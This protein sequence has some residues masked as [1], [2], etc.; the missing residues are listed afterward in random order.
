MEIKYTVSYCTKN[1]RIRKR[2]HGADE[3]RTL[4]GKELGGNWWVLK[5]N[6]NHPGLEQDINC[7]KCLR[8]LRAA[9]QRFLYN[10]ITGNDD[11]IL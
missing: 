4:C 11:P 2:I 10:P 5:Q 3:N 7:P 6:V 9:K 1:D 8:A